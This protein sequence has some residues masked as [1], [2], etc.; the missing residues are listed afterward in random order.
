MLF[1]GWGTRFPKVS[2]LCVDGWIQLD[3]GIVSLGEIY[4]FP[5]IPNTWLHNQKV[6]GV[7]R[8][9]SS[10]SS[11]SSR[12]YLVCDW[13][14]LTTYLFRLILQAKSFVL[15]YL[16]YSSCFEVKCWI[17]TFP[18]WCSH[19]A[20][21][22]L[23]L[24]DHRVCHVNSFQPA[25][26]FKWIRSFQHSQ[27]QV[28]LLLNAVCFIRLQVAFVFPTLPPFCF[29]S[30]TKISSSSIHFIDGKFLH[31]FPSMF[32]SG[33]SQEDVLLVCHF[34]FFSIGELPFKWIRSFSTSPR[35]ALSI[36]NGVCFIRPKLPLFSCPPTL[37]IQGLRFINQVSIL[38]MWS[39]FVFS[40][41]VFIRWFSWRY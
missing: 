9:D 38:W 31:S 18:K 24:L 17:H 22:I 29:S 4:C 23:I 10:S 34:N 32:L 14:I 6:S 30:R 7:Y 5:Y 16:W 13:V 33:D 39:I 20:M 15:F 36:L 2:W 40:V 27:D 26:F 37:F 25:C 35:P 12:R 1:E 21:W 8:W 11:T 19:I 28:S 3:V 41:N